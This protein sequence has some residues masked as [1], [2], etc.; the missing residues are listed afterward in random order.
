MIVNCDCD[1]KSTH[2]PIVFLAFVHNHKTLLNVLHVHKKICHLRI[3]AVHDAYDM[4]LHLHHLHLNNNNKA[5]HT[6]NHK[7]TQ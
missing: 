6:K 4:S 2:S 1:L 5:R 3:Q 7:N